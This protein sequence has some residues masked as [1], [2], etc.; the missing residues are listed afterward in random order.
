MRRITGLNTDAQGKVSYF[1]GTNQRGHKIRN[2]KVHHVRRALTKPEIFGPETNDVLVVGWGST[3]GAIEEAIHNCKDLGIKAS[4]LHLKIVYPLPLMLKE[5]F[6]KY[7]KVVTV[8]VAYGDDLKPSPLA[9][10]LRAETLVDIHP[11]MSDATGRPIR[12]SIL[13][14]RLKEILK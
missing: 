6:A 12:P 4:G 3:R 9:L 2:E 13:I 14:Q 7:K 10:M 5:I 1:A 8:E 11:L